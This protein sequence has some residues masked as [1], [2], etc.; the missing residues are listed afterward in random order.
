MNEHGIKTS[1]WYGSNNLKNKIIDKE[2]GVQFSWD[3]PLL[4]GY[5][6]EFFKNYSWKPSHANGFFGLV[7]LG[8]LIRLFQIP[9]SIIVVHG[10]HYLIH[11]I[12]LLAGRLA[13]HTICIRCDN[14]QKHEILKHGWKQQVKKIL[15][16]YI[17]F[18]RIDYYL[19]VG[20]QNKLF[21]TYFG[22][23]ESKLLFMPH[24]V[25]NARF[26]ESF[27]KL[28]RATLRYKSG[29]NL[30]DKV[31]L[32]SGKYIEKKKPL[33][34]LEAFRQF[35]QSDCWLI[36]VGEGNLKDEME[37]FISKH[38]LKRV[39][40]T[41]FIN[42]SKIVE[43][44]KISDL[45]IMYSGLGETWGLSV[46]EAMNFNLPIIVSDLTGCADDLVKEG[47]NGFITK[48]NDTVDLTQKMRAILIENQLSFE[49][50]SSEI[51][52]IYSYSTI[53]S[54]LLKTFD[55]YNTKIQAFRSAS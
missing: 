11:L 28:D 13:G 52:N 7:N 25:D 2:F 47:V 50:K 4:E 10:W 23:Q 29:I 21:Y 31:I 39:L 46:N 17:V 19:Y 36:M 18:P 8:M 54:N 35:D 43:Y 20:K 6:Y 55:Q 34:I 16:K 51:I 44:Y 38:Q 1:V 30:T 12:I 26:E 15:L 41:G 24:C 5:D 40:L 14:P 45:F 22:I 53:V 37:N 42:Q 49:T 9:K 27:H 48:S 3:I 33:E 32:F